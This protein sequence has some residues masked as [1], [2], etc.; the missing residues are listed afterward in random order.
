MKLDQAIRHPSRIVLPTFLVRAS[1]AKGQLGRLAR[2]ALFVLVEARY[3][4]TTV[5]AGPKGCYRVEARRGQA[6]FSLRQL[7]SQ[8]TLRRVS[9]RKHL[10]TLQRELGWAFEMVSRSSPGVF[11]GPDPRRRARAGTE[12]IQN[13]NGARALGVR[14]TVVDYDTITSMGRRDATGC[15]TRQVIQKRSGADPV[16]D[17]VPNDRSP[18]D[19]EISPREDGPSGATGHQRGSRRAGR[20]TGLNTQPQSASDLARWAVQREQALVARVLKEGDDDA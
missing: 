18:N 6:F 1:L 17:P 8:T 11:V 12:S 19:Q 14:V 2:L 20:S 10:V 15:T 16:R 13:S 3:Q 9:A 4:D 7:E 5:S